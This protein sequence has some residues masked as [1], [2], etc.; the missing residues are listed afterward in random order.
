[1]SVVS[2]NQLLL[3]SQSGEIDGHRNRVFLS[4]EFVSLLRRGFCTGVGDSF[5]GYLHVG[6]VS[7]PS[8]Y[9]AS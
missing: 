7:I 3:I 8:P 9:S 2:A 5:I 6:R 1:M 4:M